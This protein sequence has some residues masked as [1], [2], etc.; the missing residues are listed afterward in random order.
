[1]KL[2]FNKVQFNSE[3]EFFETLGFL[4]KDPPVFDLRTESN[5]RSGAYGDQNRFYWL[6]HVDPMSLPRP[7]MAA[8][9]SETTDRQNRIS[10]TQFINTLIENHAFNNCSD[11]NAYIKHWTKTSF[12]DV[13]NTVPDEYIAD[14]YR[15]YHW[16]M[17]IAL[18]FRSGSEPAW[19]F[20]TT[21]NGQTEGAAKQYYTIKYERS[22]KNRDAAIKLFGYKCMICGFDFEEKYGDLGKGFIEVHHINPLSSLDEEVVINPATDLICVCANC[23]RM[24]HRFKDCIVTIDDLR[25]FINDKH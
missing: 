20:E 23:H 24:L 18:H 5:K 10:E 4:T 12:S 6:Q 9:T 22:K 3:N 2:K 13:L 16:N 25:S 19:D 14:F 8:F 15:G 11:E 21:Q 17:E 7:L 1:M